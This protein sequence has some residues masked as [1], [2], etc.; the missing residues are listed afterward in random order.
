MNKLALI[1]FL[2]LIIQRVSG[3][4]TFTTTGNWDNASNWSGSNIG[5]DISE[6]VT[7][8]AN[9]TA[10]IQTGFHYTIGNLTFGNNAGLTINSGGSLN[11]GNSSNTRNVNVNNN[12]TI[13]VAGTLIIWGN[14]IV[15]NN[16]TLNITGTMIVKGNIIMNNNASLSVSGNLTVDG[17][18]V[19]GNNTNVTITG[20][21]GVSVGGTVSVG[22]NSNLTGPAGSFT[23]AGGCTQGGGSNFCTSS[24]LP[25]R[26]LF[27]SAAL[28]QGVVTLAWATEKEENFEYFQIEKAS[29]DFQF[30][31][32]GQIQG[33]GYNTSSR[34]DYIFL[35]DKPFAG[36]NYY[37]LKAI[38]F[39]GMF[40][41]FQVVSVNNE[42]SPS[43]QIYPNPVTDNIL[44][45]EINFNPAPGDRVI[46]TDVSGRQKSQLNDL[47]KGVNEYKLDGFMP[48][49]YLFQYRSHAFNKIIRLLVQ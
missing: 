17:N 42:V 35:D 21:G 28:E 20:S 5:D 23:V 38:D 45:F 37:R 43:V 16:L 18:F 47:G 8:N 31:P 34:V 24:T 7:I 12:G 32:I 40:E 33:A 41:Y 49:L 29:H 3:Q 22:N 1:L 46:I 2:A 9:R 25:V 39:D 36:I 11:V 15:D 4:A 13:T 19:G 30:F 14:L 26:L 44:R 48:G 10:F 27:F 6:N